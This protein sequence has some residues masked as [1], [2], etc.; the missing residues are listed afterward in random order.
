MRYLL[1]TYLAKPGGQIDEQVQMAKSVKPKDLQTCNIIL[2]FQKKNVDKCLIEGKVVSKDWEQLC[3]Y[4]KQI[5]PDVIDR[6]EKAQ[7][8]PP[9]TIPLPE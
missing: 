4:F 8:P 7:T 2:D 6:L 3:G 9:L 5:Y 1:I